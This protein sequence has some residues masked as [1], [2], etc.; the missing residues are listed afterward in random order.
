MDVPLLVEWS[1]GERKAI[2]FLFEEESAPGRFSIYRL[3]VYC[4]Q[5]AEQFET[6]QVIPVVI[7]LTPRPPAPTAL[8]LG[9]EWRPVMNFEPL[10]FRLG[11]LRAREHLGSTN[12]VTRITLPC[13]AYHSQ[14][15][16]AEACGE[17]LKGLIE[18]EP[19]PEKQLKYRDFIRH[20]MKLDEQGQRLYAERY[21]TE[22]A[23]MSSIVEQLRDEGR[24]EGRL[25]GRQ[26]GRQEGLAQGIQ[27]GRSQ[28]LARLLE[29]R[30]G[31]LDDSTLEQLKAAST[32]ELDHWAERILDAETL[33]EVFRVH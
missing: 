16:H 26:Q 11:Q 18:L 28:M 23:T 30:F 4:L 6:D 29:K 21:A 19:D 17:A 33:D 8:K 13:M 25:E 24:L 5:L 1:N 7:F 22:E 15:E 31:T 32:I 27:E 3:G 2:L 20:N 14:A 12:V 9:T 10:V